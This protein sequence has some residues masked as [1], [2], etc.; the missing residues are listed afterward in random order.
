M[1]FIKVISSLIV[2]LFSLNSFSEIMSWE[3]HEI[4]GAVCGSGD[5][6]SIF[7]NKR[8]SEYVQMHFQPGGACWSRDTCWGPNFRAWIRPINF[9]IIALPQAISKDPLANFTKVLFPYCTGDVFAGDHVADYGFGGKVHHKGYM[10]I[11]KAMNYM[12]KN[13]LIDFNNVIHY[14][15]TG[16]SAGAIGSLFHGYFLQSYFPNAD[17]KSLIIDSPGMHWSDTF[18]D[19]FTEELMLDFRVA[20]QY[21]GVAI[22]YYGG[23]V[24][25]NLPAICKTYSD[26]NVGII[27]SSMDAVMSSI[28]D[29]IGWEEHRN[30]VFSDFGI[31]QTSQLYENCASWSPDSILHA[32]FYLQP[33]E[34]D[35]ANGKKFYEFVEDVLNGKTQTSY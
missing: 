19:K 29:S 15:Q 13:N 35:K 30:M 34:F 27:Q 8:E 11:Y 21:V 25:R 31:F 7:I 28:F 24:I 17:Y 5:Q 4:P 10:N 23:Q 26:W 9:P 1:T 6:Y 14:A 3:R 20:A 2:L 22:D 12:V 16:S 33:F 18:W 32:Y